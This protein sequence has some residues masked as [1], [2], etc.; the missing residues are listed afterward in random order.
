MLINKNKD[1]F[2]CNIHDDNG[3]AEESNGHKQLTNVE[4]CYLNFLY[5]LVKVWSSV[6][7]FNYQSP[8][9]FLF[10]IVPTVFWYRIRISWVFVNELSNKQGTKQNNVEGEDQVVDAIAKVEIVLLFKIDKLGL[11]D[12]FK[13]EQCE[14]IAIGESW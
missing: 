9:K 3:V 11:L 7:R 13:I 2:S 8:I 4:Y 6:P 5:L 1:T 12:S 14:H 10:E